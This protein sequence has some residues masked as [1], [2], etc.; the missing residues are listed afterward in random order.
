MSEKELRDGDRVEDVKKRRATT[1]PV[2]S[3]SMSLSLA[4][5]RCAGRMNVVCC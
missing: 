1:S 4:Q 5:S 2:V 3:T